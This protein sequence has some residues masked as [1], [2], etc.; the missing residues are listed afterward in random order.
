MTTNP[1]LI[2]RTETLD[3]ATIVELAKPV[4]FRGSPS[5]WVLMWV[6]DTSLFLIYGPDRGT[7][8]RCLPNLSRKRCNEVIVCRCDGWLNHCGVK[9][10]R[11]RYKTK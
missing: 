4:S 10:L 7:C 5:K 6:R 3:G 2:E 11:R 9:W 1:W 8:H